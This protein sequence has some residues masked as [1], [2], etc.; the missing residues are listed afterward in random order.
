MFLLCPVRAC[1]GASL[2]SSLAWR[3]S[4]DEPATS[5]L[6]RCRTQEARRS[7][8][9]R[10]DHGSRVRDPCLTRRRPGLWGSGPSLSIRRWTPVVEIVGKKKKKDQNSIGCGFI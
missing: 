10:Q 2:T 4:F 8:G 9:H 1:P 6:R 7:C 3:A 5:V